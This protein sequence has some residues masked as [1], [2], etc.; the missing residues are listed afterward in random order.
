M[1]PREARPLVL[2]TNAV[3]LI[4]PAIAIRERYVY[5]L[6]EHRATSELNVEPCPTNSA[7]FTLLQC[8]GAVLKRPK[9]SQ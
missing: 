1:S 4:V 6:T 8:F 3:S 9:Q 7:V 2:H 5:G